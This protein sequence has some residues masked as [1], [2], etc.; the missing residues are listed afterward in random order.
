MSMML[1]DYKVC[2]KKW[3][4][5]RDPHLVSHFD[6]VCLKH[7]VQSCSLVQLSIHR[8]IGNLKGLYRSLKIYWETMHWVLVVDRVITC[9][10]WSLL[11][12]T[13][14]KQW[15]RC[16]LSKLCVRRSVD[17]HCFGTGKGTSFAWAWAS[18]ADGWWSQSS[19]VRN[20][21]SSRKEQELCKSKEMNPWV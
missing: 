10:L 20:E 1:Q 14:I 18:P 15:H 5:V 4:T 19:G 12:T 13:V 6:K 11:I 3:V 7:W 9:I 8:L 21:D 17:H 2:R 16:C